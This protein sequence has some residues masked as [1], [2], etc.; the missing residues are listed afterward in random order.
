MGLLLG[1]RFR[2]PAVL[3]ASVVV[4]LLSMAAAPFAGLSLLTGIL[5]TIALVSALQGGYL[6]GVIV[7]SGCL[8]LELLSPPADNE[9]SSERG[10]HGR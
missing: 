3:A 7:S 2:V 4:A 6:A 5:V 9:P 10:A 8:R 1:L